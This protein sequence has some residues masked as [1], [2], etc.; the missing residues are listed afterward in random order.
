MS[1]LVG[2][3]QLRTMDTRLA[4]FRVG[5]GFV[6]L[7]MA[8]SMLR[9]QPDGVRAMTSETVEAEA[10]AAVVVAVAIPQQAGSWV[11]R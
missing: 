6:L 11:M 4:S 10:R 3:Q 8:L 1:V 2:E 7:L 5:G 9:G